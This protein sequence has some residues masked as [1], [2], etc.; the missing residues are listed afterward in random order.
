MII[1]FA[2]RLVQQRHELWT[3]G[4]LASGRRKRLPGGGEIAKPK[5]RA[6]KMYTRF[7]CHA[8]LTIAD[9]LGQHRLGVAVCAHFNARLRD[10][11]CQRG[12]AGSEVTFAGNR[13][14]LIE[15]TLCLFMMPRVPLVFRDD[16]QAEDLEHLVAKLTRH[17][18]GILHVTKSSLRIRPVLD[19]QRS[20]IRLDLC[21]ALFV[22]QRLVRLR[23]V[24]IIGS[25]PC[26]MTECVMR[27]AEIHQ[28]QRLQDDVLAFARSCK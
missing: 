15:R 17:I 5:F 7:G 22:A 9:G 13:E 23:A 12:D 16:L 10:V 1:E 4:D 25:G 3:R 28:Q 18:Q 6:G 14:C 26:V 19:L 24:P 8:T 2:A 20:G 11:E 21:R 27:D